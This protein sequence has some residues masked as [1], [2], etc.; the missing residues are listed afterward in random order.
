MASLRQ[1]GMIN[2][3]GSDALHFVNPGMELVIVGM[4]SNLSICLICFQDF[5]SCFMVFYGCM[6]HFGW[7]VVIRS[8]FFG[9]TVLQL[10]PFDQWLPSVTDDDSSETVEAGR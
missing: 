10:F 2:C 7:Y 9:F 3:Q 1:I 8:S 4:V 5:M 6:Y